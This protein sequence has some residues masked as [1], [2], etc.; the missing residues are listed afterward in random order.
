MPT[1]PHLHADA[2]DLTQPAKERAALRKRVLDLVRGKKP[3]ATGAPRS[4][5]SP[6][7]TPTPKEL[8]TVTA[9]MI[10]PRQLRRLGPR[11]ALARFNRNRRGPQQPIRLA[12]VAATATPTPP[13]SP[14]V[15][16]ALGVLIAASDGG[17]ELS[18]AEVI[19]RAKAIWE[20]V[21]DVEDEDA[22]EGGEA[23]PADA[24]DL[25]DLFRV[26]VAMKK[27]GLGVEYPTPPDPAVAEEAAKLMAKAGF[28]RE[29][30]PKGL[31]KWVPAG[32]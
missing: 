12:R 17:R 20:M 26:A 5:P 16:N 21:E 10:S 27:K 18:D 3:R 13:A 6:S 11:L 19:E 28:R 1:I 2:R 29:P 7:P 15:L 8:P 24:T 25:D 9:E 30:S 31:E 4:Q 23:A 22:A 32:R 14:E